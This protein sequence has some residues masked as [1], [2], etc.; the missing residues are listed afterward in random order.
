MRSLNDYINE[1]ENGVDEEIA[2][3]ITNEITDIIDDIA[4]RHSPETIQQIIKDVLARYIC[5]DEGV[6]NAT[7]IAVGDAVLNIYDEY[8]K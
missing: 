8:L 5:A 4:K 7:S 6:S 1:T 3:N 2:I